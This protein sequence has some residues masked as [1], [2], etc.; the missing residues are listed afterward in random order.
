MLHGLA[1]N[2]SRTLLARLRLV[3]LCRQGLIKF[4]I[5]RIVE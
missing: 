5:A 4:F 2:A 1:L 3:G